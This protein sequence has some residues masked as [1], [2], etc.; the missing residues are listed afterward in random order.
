MPA[1][2]WVLRF[3]D[4]PSR[5]AVRARPAGR[6]VGGAPAGRDDG[7]IDL[8]QRRTAVKLPSVPPNMSD[9]ANY[10]TGGGSLPALPWRPRARAGEASA[11]AAGGAPL[12]PG[13]AAPAVAAARPPFGSLRCIGLKGKTAQGYSVLSMRKPGCRSGCRASCCRETAPGS[14]WRCCPSRRPAHPERARARPPGI[15]HR[16]ARVV[17]VPV[18][19]PLQTF[20][21]M[22]CRPHA[23]GAF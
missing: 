5:R 19:H 9:N 11:A 12:G 17:P 16:A 20:P 10:R 4:G 13:A 23:F 1:L 18:L 7:N 3:A 15:R 6:P 8:R 2:D 22:S 14:T 21:S